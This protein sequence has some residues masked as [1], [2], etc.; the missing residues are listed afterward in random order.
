MINLIQS[1]CTSHAYRELLTHV[2][3]IK[4][5]VGGDDVG[6]D[7]GEDP[8][9]IPLSSM[10]SRINPAPKTKIVMVAALRFAKRSVLLAG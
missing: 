8:L 3:D 7:G 5:M 10:E 4:H 2:M 1:P 6:D 9:E